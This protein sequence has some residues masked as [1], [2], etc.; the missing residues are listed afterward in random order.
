MSGVQATSWPRGR[1]E[2]IDG[3]ICCEPEGGEICHA[4]KGALGLRIDLLGKMA[5]GAMPFEGRNPNR[6][7]AAVIAG[8]AKL[9]QHLHDIHAPHE[10]LGQPWITPT[11]LRAGA[12]AQMNV[13]PGDCHAVGRRANG[14]QPS[15]TTS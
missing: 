13:L 9:E 12:P 5:H 2:G 15:T 14:A 1:A 10:H 7:V 3:A 8:L 4:A 11:V 6:A